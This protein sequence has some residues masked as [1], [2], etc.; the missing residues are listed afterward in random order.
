MRPRLSS[1]ANRVGANPALGAENPRP[2]G[3]RGLLSCWLG[4]LVISTG[5]KISPSHKPRT[6]FRIGRLVS[7]CTVALALWACGPVY[8][9]VPPPGQVSFTAE[10]LTD[11]TGMVHTLWTT[12]G[13]PNGN[14]ANATFSIVD[15]ESG[16]GV[17]TVAAPDGSFVAGPMQASVGDRVSISYRDAHG[18]E[19]P[20]ACRLL[21]D[22]PLAEP[23][24]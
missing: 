1:S 23:C 15:R 11:A 4:S 20:A 16:Q 6:T 17:I 2:T 8:I 22:L 10:P 24:P 14:A 3:A 9:P 19:S 13:G 21:S 18:R 7:V 12:R 5:M